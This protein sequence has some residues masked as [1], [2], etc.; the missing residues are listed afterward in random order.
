VP[1]LIYLFFNW[2]TSRLFLVFGYYKES[3]S[4]HR[5]ARFLMVLRGISWVYG[6]EWYSWVME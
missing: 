3:S 2:G 1:Q 6:H 4:G 5:W